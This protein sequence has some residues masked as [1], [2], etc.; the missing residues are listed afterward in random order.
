MASKDQTHENF[1]IVPTT[2]RV[3][4]DTIRDLGHDPHTRDRLHAMIL[5][6]PAEAGT[7]AMEIA[8][9]V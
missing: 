5:H 8:F 1:T 9:P 4:P 7:R 6:F 3:L 2:T